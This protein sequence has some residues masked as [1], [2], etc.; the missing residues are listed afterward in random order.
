MILNLKYIFVDDL[1]RNTHILVGDKEGGG[2][3]DL[4]QRVTKGRGEPETGEFS[5]TSF[6][7]DP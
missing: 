6:L 2:W 7:N 1:S 5:V 4:Q 3:E